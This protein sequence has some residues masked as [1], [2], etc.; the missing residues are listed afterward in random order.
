MTAPDAA[1][2]EAI[3]KQGNELY[4]LG[5]LA[6]AGREYEKAA[7]LAPNDPTPLS[8]LSSVKFELGEYSSAAEYI[9]KSLQLTHDDSDAAVKR[10]EQAQEVSEK[11]GDVHGILGG[12]DALN[13]WTAENAPAH[14]T[15]MLDRL[16][17]LMTN[18]DNVTK[19]YAI[20]HDTADNLF[21][22]RLQKSSSAQD[23]VA[24]MFCGS[25]DARH[26]LTTLVMTGYREMEREKDL[27]KNLHITLVDINAAAISRT[28]ILLDMIVAYS[29][30]KIKKTPGIEDAPTVMAYLY[31][32]Q[33][34]PAVVNE[35]L[36]MHIETLLVGLED[37]NEP[38]FDWLYLPPA[39]RQAVARVL[40]RWRNPP[41]DRC[42][43]PHLIRQTILAKLRRERIKTS[44]MYGQ[45]SRMKAE[46]GLE[47]DRAT[48]DD[49]G[50][51]L[52]PKGFAE[53]RDE[54]LVAMVEEYRK[55]SKAARQQLAAHIDQNW[56]TN[57][58][59]ID[60]DYSE[61]CN[62]ADDPLFP[63]DTDEAKVP[64]IEGDPTDLAMMLP[65]IL[66]GKG[67]L[68]SVGSFFA[69]TALILIQFGT[70]NRLMIEA[71]VGEMTDTMERIRW[72][73]LESRSPSPDAKIDP[74]K[75]PHKY[76]RIHMS[77]IPDYIDGLFPVA[78]YARP[79]LR[80]N[81]TSN[82][83]FTVLL[84]PPEFRSHRDYQSEYLAL[85]DDDRIKDHFAMARISGY[86]QGEDDNPQA[87]A[88]MLQGMRMNAG[89]S[90]LNAES[91]DFL[92]EGYIVWGQHAIKQLS[93][94][95][96]LL[97]RP[98]LE[99]WLHAFFLKICVPFPRPAITMSPVY[100]PLNL[101]AFLRL[102]AH[103][104][105][106]GYPAHWLS[107]ILTDLCSGTIKTTARAPQA[108]ITTPEPLSAVH[109]RLTMSTAPWAAELSA[110]VSIWSPLL[111]FGLTS[112][113]GHLLAPNEIAEFSISFQDV[114][115]KDTSQ[116]RVPHFILVF[117]KS[118]AEGPAAPPPGNV[119]HSVLREDEM[120]DEL[121]D[122][123][124]EADTGNDEMKR[125]MI[126][127][128]TT[129]KYNC[130]TKTVSFWS[131][132]DGMRE[133]KEE[134]TWRAFIWRLD[135]WTQVTEGVKVDKGSVSIG[136]RWGGEA[137]VG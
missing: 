124:L 135:R 27:C 89:Y 23:S 88:A 18:L 129:L 137:V 76:D 1:T 14:R 71:T 47:F 21:D 116:L 122:L 36:Q 50:V 93:R 11:V 3:R 15:L 35:K 33:V 38:L 134:E 90:H 84:N 48:F 127:V 85:H 49:L 73:C 99:K 28:L 98:A 20:G 7:A 61:T 109:A 13:A 46:P 56:V 114:H 39:T 118:S 4:K 101:T 96:D 51:V 78:L 83:R 112:P 54:P 60:F 64:S 53:R 92:A 75:F 58:T 12:L 37:E 110:L 95:K 2:A 79:L 65:E 102:I 77:N 59:L 133:L 131:G 119:L 108:V 136:G 19:Y 111:P 106:L 62:N 72:D 17:R 40:R 121:S 63:K 115:F 104:A 24:L 126:R 103:L 113:P 100:T 34:M 86:T 16:P 5:K 105:S 125:D 67:V 70:E 44:F 128:F 87:K 31:V 43:S 74:A 81:D 97:P 68:E 10:F 52:P 82:L 132:I 69:V 117:W 29:I 26:V 94:G 123:E 22:D 57:L 80:E 8:N 41:Q 55:G 91:I 25:G 42:Y 107:S 6:E 32:A 30:L 45:N 120:S 130:E 9:L 66:K